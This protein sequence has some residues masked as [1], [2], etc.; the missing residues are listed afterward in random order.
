MVSVQLGPIGHHTLAKTGI[1]SIFG[2]T[3]ILSILD[4]LGKT[5]ILNT[6]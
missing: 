3:G 1:L 4:I 5:R 2:K 6:H